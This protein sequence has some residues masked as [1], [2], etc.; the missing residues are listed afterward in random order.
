MALRAERAGAD[1]ETIGVRLLAD[2]FTA[3]ER[4]GA[5]RLATET[6][7]ELLVSDDEAP[8]TEWHGRPLTARGLSGLL[9]PFGIRSGTV[10]LAD[11]ATAKGYKRE[12]FEDAW[13]RYLPGTGSVSVTSVTM[14]QPS[15]KPALFYP[16]QEPDVTDTKHASNRHGYA[17]VTD[18]TDRTPHTGANELLQDS[19]RD[20]NGTCNRHPDEPKSWCLE[21]KA[22]A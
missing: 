22:T 19:L 12:A 14:A 8:W 4:T 7:L 3:F 5:E 15:R 21:C 17:G 16:S 6:L 18:V 2:S 9:K 11:D 10:R 20:A 13:T 1:D